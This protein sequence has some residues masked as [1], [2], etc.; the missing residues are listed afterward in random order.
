[1]RIA[2]AHQPNPEL[3]S[4]FRAARVE[5]VVNTLADALAQ[6]AGGDTLVVNKIAELGDSLVSVIKGVAALRDKGIALDVLSG[7]GTAYN[8]GPLGGNVA[9]AAIIKLLDVEQE[10][11]AT[12]RVPV[13]AARPRP[14]GRK[15]GRRSQVTA[16]QIMAAS[17][18]MA[19]RTMPV[20]EIGGALG[21]TRAQIYRHVAPDGELRPAGRKVVDAAAATIRE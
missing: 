3:S 4:I 20:I 21:V 16:D 10:I 2:I 12:A 14:R 15:G 9:V 7:P 18:M 6:L 19:A 13:T 5:R 1:M 11:A 8:S 17:T